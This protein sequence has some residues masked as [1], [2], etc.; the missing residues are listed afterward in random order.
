[1]S[2]SPFPG[3]VIEK[4][5]KYSGNNEGSTLLC[6]KMLAENF[7]QWKGKVHDRLNLSQAR[8]RVEEKRSHFQKSPKQQ[9][10]LL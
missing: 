6:F 8:R 7:Q 2:I 9:Q 10:L 5:V 3:C 1:M 4:D